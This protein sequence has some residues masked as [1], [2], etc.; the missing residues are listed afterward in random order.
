MVQWSWKRMSRVVLLIFL[1]Y[2]P[3][4]YLQI[5]Q[6]LVLAP[7]SFISGVSL[8]P[9]A[10]ERNTSGVG[11]ARQFAEDRGDRFDALSLASRPEQLP[12]S[13]V[14]C[15]LDTKKTNKQ[16]LGPAIDCLCARTAEGRLVSRVG[17]P[18]ANSSP[19]AVSVLQVVYAHACCE[20]EGTGVEEVRNLDFATREKLLRMLSPLIEAPPVGNIGPLFERQD[21]Q[22]PDCKKQVWSNLFTG[23]RS[24][25]DVAVVDAS[26]GMGGGPELEFLEIRFHEL[27]NVVQYFVVSESSY[28]FRGDQKDRHFLRQRKRFAAFESQILYNDLD[29]CAK[30]SMALQAWRR[31]PTMSRQK[32]V[33]SV[34]NAQR[35]C[36]WD[37]LV[38]RLPDL[39]EDALVI[40]TDLDEIPS[41]PAMA[42]LKQCEWKPTK[43][44]SAHIV[45]L[46]FVMISYN[47]RN[48]WSCN[49][50]SGNEWIQGGVLRWN[51]MRSRIPNGHG[52]PL[53]F[54]AKDVRHMSKVG[55]H[56]SYFGTL[57]QM[58]YKG[59]Q[60][61]EGGGL[62]QPHEK[63]CTL[64][65]SRSLVEATHR[66]ALD[67]PSSVFQY[68][69]NVSRPLGAAPQRSVLEA[70]CVP[71]LLLDMPERYPAFWGRWL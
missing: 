47:L 23:R 32:N 51:Q 54:R 39:G 19:D 4:Q 38:E 43:V 25:R 37:F 59:L 21:I 11:V 42:A 64:G 7:T 26:T 49:R 41:G 44:R 46:H 20:L 14:D 29:L 61:G 17:T 52:V 57:G 15:H 33:F 30:Y 66:L 56:L 45:A 2:M 31:I 65:T 28:N 10:L 8:S 70:C 1:L 67:N 69:K 53:R 22:I 6:L 62:Y 60:H 24:G 71:Q 36:V 40:H 34:Q 50:Q 16:L 48:A 5:I 9:F 55:V 35:D 18:M 63:I 3:M 27:S 58:T 12:Y 13:S 68:W